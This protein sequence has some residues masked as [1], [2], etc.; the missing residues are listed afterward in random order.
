VEWRY[1]E[2][3]CDG[4]VFKKSV[5]DDDVKQQNVKM[6]EESCKLRAL[7]VPVCHLSTGKYILFLVSEGMCNS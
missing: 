1:G 4:Q 3:T 6:T 7:I 5:A 2:L